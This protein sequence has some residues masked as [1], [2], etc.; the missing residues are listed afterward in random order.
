MSVAMQAEV[1][2]Q[3]NENTHPIV[4]YLKP[5][6]TQIAGSE[7]VAARLQIDKPNQAKS[8]NLPTS[9]L[10]LNKPSGIDQAQ[11]SFPVTYQSQRIGS[12]HITHER[13]P[14]QG[15]QSPLEH[16]SK[17]EKLSQAIGL[18]LQRYHA[19]ELSDY[20]LGTSYSVNG[21]SDATLRLEGMIEHA[22]NDK[23]SI[24]ITGEPGCETSAIACTI[25]FNSPKQ[26]APFIE[27]NCLNADPYRFQRKVA[28]TFEFAK[29]GCVFFNAIEH[30]SLE[31]QQRLLD[32]IRQQHRL[33]DSTPTHA[34]TRLMAATSK[35]LTDLVKEGKFIESLR[36]ELNGITINTPN[37]RERKEDIPHIL[38]ALTRQYQ[39][40]PTQSFSD[41]AQR[42]LSAYSWPQNY[43][44]LEQVVARL[45]SL[46]RNNLIQLEDIKRY[47]PEVFTAIAGAESNLRAPNNF[48]IIT[49]MQNREFHHFEHMHKRLQSALIYLA[50]NFTQPISI[51]QLSAHVHISPSHLSFLF[52]QHIKRTIKQVM[53][54]LRIRHA[55]ALLN[56]DPQQLITHISL[57]VGFGDL[58]HFEKVFKRYTQLTPR[59][60]KA[61]VIKQKQQQCVNGQSTDNA[62]LSNEKQG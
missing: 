8:I 1:N 19:A 43:R 35:Q 56:R 26:H 13:L 4:N 2:T 57:E 62:L 60:Y 52:K 44:E 42:A 17:L 23:Q 10:L 29:G 59:E 40:S 18:L 39:R 34:S 14:L 20:Y 27:V 12:L 36:L 58:S 21:F 32:I 50:D 49:C 9:I 45:F 15:P 24:M 51:S 46:S 22:A 55:E 5:C 38:L 16:H 33:S 37:L 41:D 47:T 28:R 54:E 3:V 53:S 6:V 31:Q 25:H 11:A 30:L 61:K 48:N 7:L